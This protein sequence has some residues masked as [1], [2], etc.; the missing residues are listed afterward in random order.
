MDKFHHNIHILDVNERLLIKRYKNTLIR[1][2]EYK[3][4][5]QKLSYQNGLDMAPISFTQREYVYG[6][7]GD[8]FSS[9]F[10]GIMNKI[11][12]HI[13]GKKCVKGNK[14]KDT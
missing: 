3:N 1:R 7:N 13:E 9:H 14:N 12:I 6:S 10:I 11:K 8:F 5:T 4:R 2:N